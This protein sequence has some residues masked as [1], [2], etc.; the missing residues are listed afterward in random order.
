MASSFDEF[1][2]SIDLQQKKNTVEEPFKIAEVTSIDPLVVELEGLPLYKNNLYINP[3]LL[4]WYE[5]VNIITSTNDNH[6]HTIS[7]IYHYSKLKIGSNV[8]CYGIEHNGTE[9]QRY[10]VLGVI[11]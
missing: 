7:T 6:N 2:N 3:Y 5:E 8:V 10:V 4:A 11:E 1:W 9:Y